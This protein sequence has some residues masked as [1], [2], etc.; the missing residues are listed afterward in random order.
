MQLSGPAERIVSQVFARAKLREHGSCVD[1][2]RVKEDDKDV[3]EESEESD[4]EIRRVDYNEGY[5]VVDV[6]YSP[7][8]KTLSLLLAV[9]SVLDESNESGLQPSACKLQ[10][11]KLQ[12]AEDD[13]SLSLLYSAGI[14]VGGIYPDLARIWPSADEVDNTV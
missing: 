4:R 3:E 8:G 5:H 11:V 10:L 14:N 6:R 2:C 7:Q 1:V 13:E 12:H 9:F